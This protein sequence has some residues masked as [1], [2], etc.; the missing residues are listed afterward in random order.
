MQVFTTFETLGISVDVVATS[1]VS[2]SLT[3]DPSRLWERALIKQA[4]FSLQLT[5][6]PS[7]V[8]FLQ[9]MANNA[10]TIRLEAWTR[11][12]GCQDRVL[13]GRVICNLSEVAPICL[14][15]RLLNGNPCLCVLLYGSGGL[16][17]E[18][19]LWSGSVVN[20]ILFSQCL[21]SSRVNI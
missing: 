7:L 19:Q 16:V 10:A 17:L 21:E 3:L 12:S 4:R 18:S 15:T 9:N 20:A 14:F 6:L 5:T 11:K 8:T 13:V 1:E 2:I